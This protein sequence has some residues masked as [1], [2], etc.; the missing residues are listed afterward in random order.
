MLQR[1]KTILATFV[2]FFNYQHPPPAPDP[3]TPKIHAVKIPVRLLL[4]ALGFNDTSILVGHFMSSPRDR[5][6]TDKKD[7]R[8]D[9]REAQGRNRNRKESEE[10]EEIKTC[11]DSRPC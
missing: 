6:K 11:K 5:E 4:I 8:A 9:E 10:T 1:K 7:S 2:F 3:P